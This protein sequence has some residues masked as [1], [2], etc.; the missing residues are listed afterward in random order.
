MTGLLAG[1]RIR[2]CQLRV[3][4]L[5]QRINHSRCRTT[6]YRQLNPAPYRSHYFGEKLHIDQSENLMFGVTHICAVD[7]HSGKIVAFAI[8]PIKNNV[9]IYEHIYMYVINIAAT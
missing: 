2:A 1:D 7:G 5:L 3:C 8:M 9:V 6:T 4:R